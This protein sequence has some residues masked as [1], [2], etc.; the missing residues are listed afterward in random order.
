MTA[1]SDNPYNEALITAI[2]AQVPAVTDEQVAMVLNAWNIVQSGDPLGT[3][4]TDP[5][6]GR[7]AVRVA[8]NGV[9]HWRVTDP[10]GGSWVE[11]TP[12]LPGW[13]VIS[14]AGSE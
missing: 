14:A 8:M 11:S 6:T 2:S 12:T 9:H 4:L 10:D 5:E 13:T 3:V 1:P 7:V